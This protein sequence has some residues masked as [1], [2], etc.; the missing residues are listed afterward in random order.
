MA[1]LWVSIIISQFSAKA[2]KCFNDYLT[3]SYKKGILKLPLG[4]KLVFF[5]YFHKAGEQKLNYRVFILA[6]S[7]SVSGSVVFN[8]MGNFLTSNTTNKL[9]FNINRNKLD[10]YTNIAFE[11]FIVVDQ[12][13]KINFFNMLALNRFLKLLHIY[14]NHIFNYY[15]FILILWNLR[16]T[17]NILF[18]KWTKQ[19]RYHQ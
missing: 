18:K 2:S 6:F 16:K 1:V 4:I 9:N 5:G 14:L 13:V 11:I 3:F 7:I 17:E 12:P 8:S 15:L 10:H 19:T